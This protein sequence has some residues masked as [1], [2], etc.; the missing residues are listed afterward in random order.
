MRINRRIRSVDTFLATASKDTCFTPAVT[1]FAGYEQKIQDMGFSWP[2]IVGEAVLPPG[3]CGNACSRNANGWNEKHT[4]RGLEEYHYWQVWK[5]KMDR[6]TYFDHGERLVRRDKKRYPRTLHP[7]LSMELQVMKRDDGATVLAMPS[8]YLANENKNS[9]INGINVVV[10]I[11][12]S[13]FLLN[14]ALRPI[15][16]VRNAHWKLVSSP[17]RVWANVEP[18]LND[19]L[20]RLSD[21]HRELLKFRFETI[22]ARRPAL[23][24]I[25]QQGFLGHIIL[26]FPQHRLCLLEGVTRRS[27]VGIEGD[28]TGISQ[29]P[30]NLL[31]EEKRAAFSIPHSPNWRDDL[32]ATLQRR[33]I[34]E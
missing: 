15:T 16:P 34:G 7:P 25:G 26:G 19:V 12:G 23:C 1:Q 31:L 32:L 6:K 24:A 4:D 22:N 13:C 11:F 18:L 21:Q 29:L 5:W 3:H 33:Q 27:T 2:L 14:E 30:I 8:V 20:V 28:W 9:L 10:E 17:K